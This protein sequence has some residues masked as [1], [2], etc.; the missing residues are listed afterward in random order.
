M[1]SSNHPFTL[2]ADPEFFITDKAG[3]PKSIIGR[4]GGTKEHPKYIDETNKGFAIQ[5]D[6]VAAEFNIPATANKEHLAGHIQYPMQA[7]ATILGTDTF[8]ISTESAISFP[9]T[10]L[11]TAQAWIFGCEPDYDAWN[12]CM[13][14]KPQAADKNLRTAGGHIH[15]GFDWNNDIQKQIDLVKAMD[16]YLGIWSVIHD[17]GELRKQLY[18]KAGAFRPK[19][20]GIE[21]RVL[22]NFWIFNKNYIENIWELTQKAVNFVQNGKQ[23]SENL[24][25]QIQDCINLG[26]KLH[27]KDLQTNWV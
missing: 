16:L 12:L 4:I 8:T 13:N 19:P 23:I 20:Y 26:D 15:V 11:N 5:E 22:S 21:Y 14:E 17:D 10:E 1:S 3:N 24:G 6:N 7:I 25:K 27:A 2:G 9:E 18:G